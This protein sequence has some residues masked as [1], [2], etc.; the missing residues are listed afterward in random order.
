MVVLKCM[1]H[2]W[3]EDVFLHRWLHLFIKSSVIG[4]QKISIH[5]EWAICCHVWYVYEIGIRIPF[6]KQYI[7]VTYYLHLYVTN[8]YTFVCKIPSY[9]LQCSLILLMPV[10]PEHNIYS[11]YNIWPYSTSPMDLFLLVNWPPIHIRRGF[12]KHASLKA[13]RCFAMPYKEVDSQSPLGL[14]WST[15]ACRV[16]DWMCLFV[17]VWVYNAPL[18]RGFVKCLKASR[19]L[20][21]QTYTCKCELLILCDCI[22]K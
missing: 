22:Y 4:W 18:Y 10:S 21:T 9:F 5:Q 12:M 13:S 16:K 7:Y 14:C 6:P 19:A 20:Y 3:F 11:Y 1:F 8:Y 2:M 15:P 17:Y